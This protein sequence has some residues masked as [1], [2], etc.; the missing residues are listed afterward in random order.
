MEYVQTLTAGATTSIPVNAP[1]AR[2]GAGEFVNPFAESPR[3]GAI[4]RE[5]D[6]VDLE[7]DSD[8]SSEGDLFVRRGLYSMRSRTGSPI[9]HEHDRP[10]LV[11]GTPRTRIEPDY[12]ESGSAHH[13]SSPSDGD[14]RFALEL[15]AQLDEEWMAAPQIP[16][17]HDC[18]D[19]AGGEMA[20]SHG[21][22]L[23]RSSSVH[24]PQFDEISEDPPAQPLSARD[25]ARAHWAHLGDG[26]SNC[27]PLGHAQAA[28]GNPQAPS[29]AN[30]VMVEIECIDLTED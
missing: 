17:H 13:P 16:A 7:S 29:R 10:L 2:P 15:Q 30:D 19:V 26:D 18:S 3:T 20:S 22:S 11:L 12:A 4:Y 25:A 14:Y 28:P 24:Q 8:S 27:K 1:V 9:L 21:S 5:S 23:G 6:I